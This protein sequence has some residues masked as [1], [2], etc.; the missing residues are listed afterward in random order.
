MANKLN[1]L[2]CFVV[3]AGGNVGRAA[4]DFEPGPLIGEIYGPR[5]MTFLRA[6]TV[7][8]ATFLAALIASSKDDNYQARTFTIGTY[9]TVTP[10]GEAKVE[11]TFDNGTKRTLRKAT[12]QDDMVLTEKKCYHTS[13]QKTLDG[14]QSS[15]GVIE[16]H[17]QLDGTFAIYGRNAL[18]AQ[19]EEVM[20][21][22]PLSTLDVS[23]YQPRT[24]GDVG[25]FTVTR[26]FQSATQVDTEYAVF[27]AD[28]NPIDAIIGLLTA[29]LNATSTGPTN[30]TV[31]GAA[32]C[33]SQDLRTNF[34]GDLAVV[35]AWEVTN[36]LT[37]GVITVASV[38]L[39]STGYALTIAATG[40]DSDNPGTGGSVTVK[41]VSPSA[42]AGLT[43][44]V[45][46][47]ESNVVTVTL[48]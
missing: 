35:P 7:D 25:Q 2:D 20:G 48:G 11:K 17:D 4:C 46:G 28:F 43:V 32:G 27:I 12:R 3:G 40:V 23:I 41:L 21:F 9:Q 38:A 22:F 1:K 6:D 13:V 45:E 39:T 34:G 37:G 24:Y 10:S 18:D 47:I 31:T 5:N 19:A 36:T 14:Q 29:K 16:I 8:E 33:G 30:I 42:L 15:L 44:P 26:G